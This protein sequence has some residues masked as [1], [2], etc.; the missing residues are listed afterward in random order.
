MTEK[1]PY[2]FD[3]SKVNSKQSKLIR[4]NNSYI[5]TLL[6]NIIYCNGDIDKV[7][8]QAPAQTA[9]ASSGK[10]PYPDK[11][12]GI[13]TNHLDQ[14]LH[15]LIEILNENPIMPEYKDINTNKPQTARQVFSRSM[16][17]VNFISLFTGNADKNAPYVWSSYKFSPTSAVPVETIKQYERMGGALAA[18]LDIYQRGQNVEVGIDLSKAFDALLT[19]GSDGKYKLAP[20]NSLKTSEALANAIAEQTRIFKNTNL[21]Q[22]LYH[23]YEKED[24]SE[25]Y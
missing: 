22:N 17:A 18:S 23:H 12:T 6:S 24:E 1:N 7:I 5:L 2:I 21:F 16:F 15:D 14:K 20:N 13:N 10:L 19:L 9:Q 25:N 11:V 3:S 4:H 8:A